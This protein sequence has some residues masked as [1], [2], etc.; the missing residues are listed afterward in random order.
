[1][2]IQYKCPDCGADMVFESETGMLGCPNCGLHRDVASMGPQEDEFINRTL[3]EEGEVFGDFEDFEEDIRRETFDGEEAVSYQCNNCGAVIM[4]TPD[5]TATTCS[6]CGAGVILGDRLR[7]QLAPTKIIPFSVSKSQAQDAF[8]KW[9]KKGLL[10]PKGF[11]SAD[12]IKS[13]TGMYVPFWLYDLNGRGEANASCT[14]V[15][16][17][18]RGD[19]IY[20]ETKYFDVYRKVDLNYDNIPVD[21]SE[22]MNDTLMDKLEPFYYNELK[23]FNT[24]YLSGFLA[25][26]YNYDDKQ[27]FPRVRQRTEKYVNDYIQST[28]SG[29]SSTTFTRKWIDVRPRKAEY[30]LL[31][32]WMISYDYEQEEHMFAMNGQTGKIVGKPPLSKA[33]IAT[34]FFGLTAGLFAI[35]RVIT[36]LMGGPII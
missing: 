17:Y 19:Y 8:R 24:P 33:K 34:W 4:T 15:R 27:L 12:R 3:A 2:V 21:A 18:E 11:A 13:I 35:M 22:K 1:M 14:Q 32:V 9:C 30:A 26:K 25:E 36:V 16:H 23:Q 7:G 10:T 6:F 20:T 28:I 29:Y 31:P 5:T